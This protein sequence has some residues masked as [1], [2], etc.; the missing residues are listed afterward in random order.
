M[1]YIQINKKSFFSNLDYFSNLVGNKNKLSIALKDNA[2]GH[3][4]KQI[5]SLCIEY[6]IKHVFVKNDFEANKIKKFN[7]ESILIL[8][9]NNSIKYTKNKH[10]SINSLEQLVEIKNKSNIEL[11]I[12][13][14]MHR[15]G[16][17]FIEIE[18]AIKTIIKNKLILK[19]VYTHFA[20]ADENTT[21]LIN[22]ENEFNK[23]IKKIRKI[24]KKE[25]KIHCANTSASHKINNSQYDMARI[26]LGSYGYIDLLK[27]KKKLKPI[28]SLIANKI[29]SRII[30]KNETV[31][32][33]SKSFINKKEKLVISNY[34]IGYGDGFFRINEYTECMLE[35]N[36]KIL[37]RVSMD[38][39]SIEGK[40]KEIIIFSNVENLAKLHNT[41][42]Y[43]ILTNLSPF[44]TRKIIEK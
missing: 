14:G 15:N 43:E 36:I 2:Y 38:S 9:G 8:Y 27:Y 32:Y 23:S 39:L 21:Q 13:T 16:I 41:I 24:Y 6:G 20:S 34:D 31:G 40:K 18:E 25:F 11:K 28:L 35:K 33:G 30:Y 4:I 3:G 1:A 17:L 42:T 22:Q 19:G 12:D 7:F 26:G 44:L 37:G 5:A 10:I 29:S